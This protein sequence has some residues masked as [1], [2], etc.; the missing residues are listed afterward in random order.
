[1]QAHLGDVIG[2]PLLPMRPLPRRVR[3]GSR[4][5]ERGVAVGLGVIAVTVFTLLLVVHLLM[6]FWYWPTRLVD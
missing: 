3:R 5:I 6:L 2:E 1:M 4:W